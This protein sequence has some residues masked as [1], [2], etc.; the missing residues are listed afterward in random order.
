[1]KQISILI[2]DN[3]TLLRQTLSH[4]LGS[5][6]EFE[7]V[8]ECA[9]GQH[10]IEMVKALR[11]SVVVMDLNLLGMETSEAVKQVKKYSPGSKVL[12]I[13]Q[14]TQPSYFRKVMRAG[15]LGYITKNSPKEEMYE[16]I[17]EIFEGTKY[18]CNEMKNIL[19]NSFMTPDNGAANIASL[20]VRELEII[21]YIRKGLS[22]REIA[23]NLHITAKT[24][25]VHRSNILRKLQV[26]NSA[27][28]INFI[29]HEF[30]E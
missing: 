27:S 6:P 22:S 28:L 10:A 20:S 17:K 9:S 25:E 2:A 12:C 8:G 26:R 7:V 29:N 18:I 19:C 30:P 16:A 14:Y 3:Y 5:H 13:S 24:I 1:M 11:P 15:A 4:L 23:G 21:G